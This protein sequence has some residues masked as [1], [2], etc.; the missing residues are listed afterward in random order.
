M[1]LI[2]LLSFIFFLIGLDN[3]L[4]L[5]VERYF[6]HFHQVFKNSLILV[7]NINYTSNIVNNVLF[8]T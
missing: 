6:L 5:T 7:T 2:D 8:D 4:I 3:N 1:L